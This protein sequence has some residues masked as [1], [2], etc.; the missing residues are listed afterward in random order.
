MINTIQR[1]NVI[2]S[3]MKKEMYSYWKAVITQNIRQEWID[4]ENIAEI[5]N[6]NSKSG[7]LT[8]FAQRMHCNWCFL[9]LQSRTGSSSSARTLDITFSKHFCSVIRK[10]RAKKDHLLVLRFQTL[11]FFIYQPKY[12]D[13]G[14]PEVIEVFSKKL[15]TEKYHF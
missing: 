6:I 12:L 2:K 13:M 8:T 1:Q 3:D 4:K 9:T 10:K 14:K 5:S 15:D 11:A 7:Y